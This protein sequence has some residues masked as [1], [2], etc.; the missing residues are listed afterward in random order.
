MAVARRDAT[1]RPARTVFAGQY[2]LIL[3]D[4]PEHFQ[5]F[6]LVSDPAER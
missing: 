1:A 6:N 4:T 3:S 5:L 2:K